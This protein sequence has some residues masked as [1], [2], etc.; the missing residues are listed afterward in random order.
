MMADLQRL[1]NLYL[2]LLRRRQVSSNPHL[3]MGEM[4][5]GSRNIFI[6]GLFQ[7]RWKLWKS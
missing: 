2:S 7:S 1:N 6:K 3:G 5:M 4:Q